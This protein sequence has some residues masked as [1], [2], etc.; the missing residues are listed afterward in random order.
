MADSTDPLMQW[1]EQGWVKFCVWLA[2]RGDGVAI[3]SKKGGEDLVVAGRAG[4]Q[5][6]VGRAR[7]ERN[8]GLDR[9]HIN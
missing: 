6:A 8:R 3:T 1:S 9:R 7:Y 5:G 4:E 2:D